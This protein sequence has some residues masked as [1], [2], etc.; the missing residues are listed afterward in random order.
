MGNDVSGGHRDWPPPPQRPSQP[1]EPWVIVVFTV[2][3]ALVLG[4]P[5]FAWLLTTLP[6]EHPYAYA[7]VPACWITALGVFLTA[8]AVKAW[9]NTK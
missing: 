9:R 8:V 7:I 1:P 3:L 2:D 4:S 6:G 5:L